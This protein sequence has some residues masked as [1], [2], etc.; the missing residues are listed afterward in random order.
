MPP[1]SADKPFEFTGSASGFFVMTLVSTLMQ[2]IP[3]VGFAMAFNYQNE[4]M[5]KN[6]K[7][8]GQNLTYKAELGETWV[9]LFVGILLIILTLGIYLFWFAP[10]VYRFVF[11]HVTVGDPAEVPS[12]ATSLPTTPAQPVADPTVSQNATPQAITPDTS[13][14]DGTTPSSTPPTNPVQ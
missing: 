5:V 10:K 9:M 7:M 14:S 3:F 8:N 13:A 4:W 6:T 12:S 11:D 2:L 1:Q